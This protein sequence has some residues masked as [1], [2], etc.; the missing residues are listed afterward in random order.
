M[1][2]EQREIKDYLERCGGTDISFTRTRKHIHVRWTHTGKALRYVVAS[3]A[4]DH[5]AMINNLRDMRG[6]MGLTKH[7]KTV[8]K[9]REKKRRQASPRPET[10]TDNY[11][12]WHA[13]RNANQSSSIPS[14]G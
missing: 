14:D 8:G 7:E 5:R 9:R 1:T 2:K 11:Q 6:L 13:W 4:S 3:S 10:A 12:D